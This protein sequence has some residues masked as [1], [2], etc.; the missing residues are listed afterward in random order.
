MTNHYK[1]SL[2]STNINSP[3]YFLNTPC[4]TTCSTMILP[5]T[6]FV[7][8]LLANLST[9]LPNLITLPTK[10]NNLLNQ[11]YKLKYMLNLTTYLLY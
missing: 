2:A 3:I 4:L 7:D 9:Y 6:S 1:Q 8:Y 11:Y 5:N 10:S